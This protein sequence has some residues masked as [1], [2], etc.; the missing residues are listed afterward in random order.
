MQMYDD[1]KWFFICLKPILDK[2]NLRHNSRKESI[3]NSIYNF[4]FIKSIYNFIYIVFNI[5]CTY[6]LF[7]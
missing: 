3:Y 6:L 1:K 7:V 5:F 2:F 4:L